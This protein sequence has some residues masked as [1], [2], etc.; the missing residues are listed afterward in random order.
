MVRIADKIELD[1]VEI[2]VG[3]A[4]QLSKCPNTM[5]QQNKQI[6]FFFPKY[7]STKYP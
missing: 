1:V 5:L 6:N 3:N 7:H 2:E 4:K